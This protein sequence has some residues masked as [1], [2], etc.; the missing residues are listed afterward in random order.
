MKALS[1]LLFVLFAAISVDAQAVISGTWNTGTDNTKVEIKK[2][3][4]KYI[5]E[6]VSSDNS[7]ATKGKQI[8]KDVT[9]QKGEW[10]GKIYVAQ[11]GK[12]ADA[13]FVR[14]N[15]TLEVIIY[16]GWASK[17]V[18]WEKVK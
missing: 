6:V 15:D 8:V 10:K 5:G 12:W 18:T 2:V 7:K 1:V 13:K 11:K 4:D 3:G 17:T 16:S 9:F 14:K